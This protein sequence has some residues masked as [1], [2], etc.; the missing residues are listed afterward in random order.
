[1]LEW[2]TNTEKC[3]GHYPNTYCYVCDAKN[4]GG[5]VEGRPMGTCYEN[6]ATIHTP[7]A[8]ESMGMIGLYRNYD[9][10][11]DN[12]ILNNALIIK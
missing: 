2:V 12:R 9:T 1:M 11:K 10:N 7:E 5:L 3:R 6:G 8:L 4:N